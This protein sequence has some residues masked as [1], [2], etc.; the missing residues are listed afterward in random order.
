MNDKTLCFKQK[1]TLGEKSTEFHGSQSFTCQQLQ[2]HLRQV[3]GD[4]LCV[5]RAVP[6]AFTA[7]ALSLPA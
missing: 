1:W 4:D 7:G 6:P 5:G 2:K 3:L